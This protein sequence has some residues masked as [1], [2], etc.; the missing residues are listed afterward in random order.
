MSA[1]G[2]ETGRTTAP[3]PGR[4]KARHLLP[5]ACPAS[6]SLAGGVAILLRRLKY[7]P[8]AGRRLEGFQQE[9]AMEPKGRGK[10]TMGMSG[11]RHGHVMEAQRS[12]H[13]AVKTPC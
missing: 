6:K 10:S 7:H 2:D 9:P 12:C 4:A 1:A 8:A 3:W 11:N 13:T 5:T